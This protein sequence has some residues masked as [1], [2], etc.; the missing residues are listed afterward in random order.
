MSVVAGSLG[1]ALAAIAGREH[2]LED[3]AGRARFAVDGLEPR[4]VVRPASLEAV[5]RLLALAHD[6]DLAVVPRGGGTALELGRPPARLDLVLDLS[7]LDRIVEYSPDDLT[8][9]VEAGVTAGALAARLAAHRQFLPLD[10]PAAAARTLGGIAATNASGPLRA[11]YGAMRDLLLGVRF[12]QADGVATWGGAKVVKSVS[13]YDVPKLMVGALGTLGVLGELTLR[14]HPAPEFEAGWL[15]GFAEAAA[16]QA[17]VTRLLESTVQPSRVELL[18]PPALA[19]CGVAGMGAAVAVSIAT[20]EAAVRA[21]GETVRA[22]VREARGTVSPLA[23][24]F[25]A[26]Y[27]RAMAPEGGVRLAIATLASKVSETAGELAQAVGDEC[28]G[29]RATI[30]GCVPVGSLRVWFPET[31]PRRVSGV[32]QWLRQFVAPIGGSVIIQ[33]AP[34]AVRAAVDPWGPIEAGPLALMRG[35]RDEFDPKRVLNPG[36]FVGGL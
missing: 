35:L 28:S 32:I 10:P 1:W 9:T 2:V 22:F 31:D 15:A 5:G 8:I 18:N 3:E 19:A 16:A 30:T 25:W 26:G 33:K 4:W 17:F 24:G 36:R 29:A 12:V 27:E 21:Q 34:A 23:D 13:G 11:R 6:A 20:A 7:R 14:L